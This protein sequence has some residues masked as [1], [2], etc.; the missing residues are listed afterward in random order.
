[1]K[2]IPGILL[3]FISIHSLAQMKEGRIV[4][5]RVFQMPARMFNADPAIAAQI[6]K[7]RTDQFELLFGNNKSLWQF[8]PD[9]NNDGDGNTISN[10][11]MVIRMQG[12]SNEVSYQDFTTATRVDHREVAERSF[13]VTDS[14]RKLDWKLSDETKT[15][16]NYTARKATAKRIGQRPQVTMENG[17]MKREMVADTATVEAWYTTDIP[18]PAGPSDYQGQLPGLILEMDINKGQ[19]V[20]KAVEITAKVNTNKIREPKEGKKVTAAEYAVERE[21]I[22]EEMRRNM[23]AGGTFRFQQ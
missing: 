11:N 22:M 18:V 12:P 23:P 15:I 19:T 20:F 4:Y 17:Q 3:L 5:E 1:M 16:L 13:V 14:I 9:A 10:G 21:K 7:S 2:K 8:L 6:P